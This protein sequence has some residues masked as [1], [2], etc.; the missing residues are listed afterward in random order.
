[1]NNMNVNNEYFQ[2]HN[3]KMTASDPTI[4]YRYDGIDVT[5]NGTVSPPIFENIYW[6][7]TTPLSYTYHASITPEVNT[8]PGGSIGDPSLLVAPISGKLTV[9]DWG[10]IGLAAC[11]SVAQLFEPD[12]LN[13]KIEPM[14]K[15]IYIPIAD[16]DPDLAIPNKCKDDI[17]YPTG[18]GIY[19]TAS[20]TPSRFYIIGRSTYM[21][22]IENR[23]PPPGC[24]PPETT[25][26][27]TTINYGPSGKTEEHHAT[28][29]FSSNESNST[30]ECSLDGANYSSCTSPNY[31][32]DL[33]F[34]DHTFSV[35]AI[36]IIGSV[37]AT[38][39]S[40][41]WTVVPEICGPR[42]HQCP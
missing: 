34:G 26:P 2:T 29:H 24:Q 33:S 36:D 5:F 15:P 3:M 39:A 23:F 13:P 35:R 31:Y 10:S 27:E 18:V 9:T 14:V 19:S 8:Q 20:D 7:G 37:D 6:C 30:F 22:Q 40:R 41:S 1:V 11:V 32:S 38:P 28:L 21:D 17:F 16:K 12:L 4:Q 42:P 25:P